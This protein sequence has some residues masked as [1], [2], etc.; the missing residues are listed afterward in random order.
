YFAEPGAR[1]WARYSLATGIFE[2]SFFIGS[3]IVGAMDENG[4]IHNAPTGIL[5]R[6]SI[7]TG[8]IWLSLVAYRELRALPQTAEAAAEQPR[9][10]T[11]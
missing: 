11:A 9:V 1:N 4:V 10:V 2:V 8:W 7:V 3:T 6:I 5:Q